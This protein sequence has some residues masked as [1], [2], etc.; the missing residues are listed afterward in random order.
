MS[1]PRPQVLLAVADVLKGSR[2]YS[3]LLALEMLLH[4][5]ADTHGNTYNRLLRDGEVVLQLHSWDDEDHPNLTDASQCPVGHGVLVWF[6]VADFEAAVER[7]RR[8]KAKVVLE[9]HVNPGPRHREIWLQDPD[10]YHVV[11]SGP[12]GE[13]TA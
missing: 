11:L 6:E 3:Q 7:S 13:S 9:P 2:C 10:G 5:D 4:T 12:D 1:S 8:L